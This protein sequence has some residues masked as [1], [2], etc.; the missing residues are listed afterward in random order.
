MP[1]EGF[2]VVVNNETKY[3]LTNE[4][5]WDMD[6]TYTQYSYKRGIQ[7]EK[8]DTITFYNYGDGSSWETM[9]IDPASDGK[10]TQEDYGLVCGEKGTYDF[11]IKL[12]YGNDNV[13][14]GKHI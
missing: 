4:G 5:A 3:I 11:Y 8:W 6:N 1:T 10:F 13:F 2:A 9:K 14:I 7:L 12:K